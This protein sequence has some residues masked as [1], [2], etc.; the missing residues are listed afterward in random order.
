MSW[1]YVEKPCWAP[2][3]TVFVFKDRLYVVLETLGYLAVMALMPE[4]VKALMPIP[5]PEALIVR[6][7][8]ATV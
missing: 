4:A 7:L 3:S 1:R 8:E 5:N 2:T 6:K